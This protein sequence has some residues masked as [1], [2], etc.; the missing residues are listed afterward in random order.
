MKLTRVCLLLAMLP[1]IVWSDE[2]YVSVTSDQAKLKMK[3]SDRLIP[4]SYTGK[5]LTAFT[6]L[7]DKSEFIKSK[8]EDWVFGDENYIQIQKKYLIPLSE[9]KIANANHY[10]KGCYFFTLGGDGLGELMQPLPDGGVLFHSDFS[11]YTS[12]SI[13]WPVIEKRTFGSLLVKDNMGVFRDGFG[14]VVAYTPISKN[15]ELI[16]FESNEPTEFYYKLE[17]KKEHGFKESLL[18]Y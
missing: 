11:P 17:C 15:N 2:M 5:P 13:N 1:V 12:K 18:P 8:A 16:F 6:F 14:R 4:N 3:G 9:F 7:V 10:M